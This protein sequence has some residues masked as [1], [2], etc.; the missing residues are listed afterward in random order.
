M[1]YNLADDF[2]DHNCE[3]YEEIPELEY[4]RDPQ[5]ASNLTKRPLGFMST[6]IPYWTR[7]KKNPCFKISLSN[8]TK[9]TVKVLVRKHFFTYCLDMYLE[10]FDVLSSTC[11]CP[12]NMLL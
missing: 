6:V 2:D 12:H 7:N 11:C 9:Q 1:I 8:S 3:I 5:S 10:T 4:D